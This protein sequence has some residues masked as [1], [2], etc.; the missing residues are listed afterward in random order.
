MD[1]MRK[2]AEQNQEL[3]SENVRLHHELEQ[4]QRQNL[5]FAADL[6]RT[7]ST[8]RTKTRVLSQTQDQL[9]R[10]AKLATLGQMVAAIAHDVGN[11]ISPIGGYADLLLSCPGLPE[12][13]K[14]YSE[15]IQQ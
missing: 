14:K 12:K 4:A 1:E 10:S 3:A 7:F 9:A 5:A 11:M 15:R 2:D 8:E 13:G 6:A